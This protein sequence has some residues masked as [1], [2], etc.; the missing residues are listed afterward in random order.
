[1]GQNVCKCVPEHIW[2]TE[3]GNASH[4]YEIQAEVGVG[5][6]TLLGFEETKNRSD[7]VSRPVEGDPSPS[8]GKHSYRQ[9]IKGSLLI[10]A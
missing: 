6:L 3:L 1:M 4:C 7:D 10:L 5:A 9:F 2:S 8:T